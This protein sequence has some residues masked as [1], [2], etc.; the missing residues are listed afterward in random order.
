[1]RV[2]PINDILRKDE[3][4]ANIKKLVE[5]FV[6]NGMGEAY[7]IE[8]RRRTILLNVVGTIGIINLIPLG[9]VAFTQG[10]PALGLLDLIFAT[11]LIGIIL[12]L[13]RTGYHII[14]SYFG[15]FFAGSLF[16]F[17]FITGGVNNTGHLWCYTFPIFTSFLLGSKRGAIVTSIL[18]GLSI[19]VFTFEDYSSIITTYPKDFK[20]RFIP[21]FLV[22]FALSY[23][24]ENIRENTE[25]Q[26]ADKKTDL[27]ERIGE[28]KEAQEKEKES[29]L[30]LEA[31]VNA[32]PDV[33]GVQ[34]AH[35]GIIRY[36][37][38]GYKLLNMS[39]EDVKGKK[40]FQLIGRNVPC[41][42][43]AP[44][45]AYKT[46]QPAQVEKYV[47]ELGVWLDVRA[48]PILDEKG[49]IIK[50]VEHLRNIDKEKLAEEALLQSEERYRSLVE[51]TM[52]GY[53]VCEIPSGRFRFLNQRWCELYGYKINEGLELKIWDVISAGEHRK[54][55][56]LIDSGIEGKQ[57]SPEHQI[58][59]A[60][61]KDGSTF[62][63]EIS[64]S[65]VN[66]QENPAFQGV[67]RD[68]T[69]K[70]R[71][72]RQLQQ[73]QRMEAI[74]TLAGGVAHDFNNLLMG[75]QGNAS[76]ILLDVDEN[77][78]HHEKL[79]NIETYVKNGADLTKQLLGYARGG[80]YEVKPTDLNELVKKSSEMFVRTKKEI[81]IHTK[82]QEEIW[83]VEVDQGQM[84]QVLL[85]L[86][87]NAWQA[88]PAGGRLYIQTENVTFD[89]K[90]IK[91]LSLE[92]GEYV[93]LSVTDTGVGMG[94]ATQQRIFDPFFTTKDMGRG[95]GLGM[96]SA[97]GIIK[98]H[99]GI[100]TV[101]SEKGEGTTFEIYLPATGK[102]VPPKKKLMDKTLKGTEKVLLVD[103]EDMVI[104]VGGQF[105]ERMGYEVLLASNGKDAIEVYEKNS[106]Q[107][108]IV[109]LDMIMPDMGGG[110]V[111]DRLKE[112][113]PDIKVLLSSGYSIDGKAAEIMKRGCDGFIQKPFNIADLSQKLREIL[114]K[115]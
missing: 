29:S 47:E 63:I 54:I 92:F 86:Y 60:V 85:N 88:M 31:I 97:Y 91:P 81:S 74:G 1:M 106:D 65:I 69:E 82:Y 36:N 56:N 111:Y 71:L 10:T 76:L 104:D 64:T 15:V 18:F 13:R 19:L 46:K 78:P 14:F 95:T 68:V 22:V 41:D 30:M 83:S 115:Q 50:V 12:C 5:N 37:E 35:H 4:S 94:Q 32:I 77:H 113:N 107:I 34:D 9:I 33:L 53:F 66:Y 24:Y 21:S 43:C 39:Y 67:I 2:L 108:G 26:L 52:Y 80:K 27:E 70:E 100:I 17:L 11:V 16:L 38:A 114:D 93:K 49:K 57:N 48:Y 75:I 7:D 99:G 73:A 72:E 61:H 79:K 44:S 23:F 112:M 96:A 109:I 51:N 20:I 40:C 59:T 25:Q 98:N 6:T 102:V 58:F 101:S 45:E 55:Q 90:F 42:I 103:D 105:L 8:A 89:E 84:E 62:R 110:E 28:L 87:V 3:M